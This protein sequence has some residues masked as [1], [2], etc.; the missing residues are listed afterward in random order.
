MTVRSDASFTPGVAL[1]RTVAFAPSGHS[2]KREPHEGCAVR[3]VP[4]RLWFVWFNQINETNQTNQ[5]NQPVLT[6]HK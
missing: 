4:L 2:R 6:L 5:S 1:L 3:K